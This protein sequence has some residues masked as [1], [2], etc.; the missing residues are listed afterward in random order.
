[1]TWKAP[2]RL[3]CAMGC[4][5]SRSA[6]PAAE[7]VDETADETMAELQT[8]ALMK[9][10]PGC[11]GMFWRANPVNGKKG[12]NDNWPR[13]GAQ[14]KGIVHEVKGARWLECKEVKQHGGSW[15]ACQKDQ[16]M[17]F[18]YSQYYLQEA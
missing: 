5:S 15:K 7:T 3:H 2:L 12:S 16:W 1:M 4:S 10:A 17:P 11:T 13:D 14:L 9:N 8:F 18:R 6:P